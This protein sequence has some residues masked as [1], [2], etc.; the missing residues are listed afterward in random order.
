M[1]EEL[2]GKVA[3]VTGAGS[4]GSGMGRAIALALAREGVSI[5]VNDIDQEG[6]RKVADEINS[7]GCQAL[8]IVADV[9]RSDEVDKMV[10]AAL[11]KFGTIDIL[12]NNAGGH[13][14]K[15]ASF[16]NESREA[17]WDRVLNLNLKGTLNCSR[18]VVNHMMERKQGK[19]V[20]I[21]SIVGLYGRYGLADYAAAKGAII[22]FTRSIAQI[23]RAH[24]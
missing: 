1:Y 14:K 10:K 9:T 19:I 21:A 5:V 6:T 4:R 23:G 20:N 16:F 3:I 2:K 15:D 17:V 12:V 13:A 24:V 7:I 22:S 11:S 8:A 18:A